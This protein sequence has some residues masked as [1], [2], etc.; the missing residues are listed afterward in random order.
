MSRYRLAP[1]ARADLDE[2]FERIAEH[3]RPAALNFVAALRSK[4]KLLASRPLMGQAMPDL[5]ENLR[6]FVHGN[7][8]VLFRPRKSGVEIMRVVHAAR[9]LGSALS[10]DHP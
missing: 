2:I 5:S 6:S 9:D 7:Y 3:D 4:F 10:E 1:Q 8:L